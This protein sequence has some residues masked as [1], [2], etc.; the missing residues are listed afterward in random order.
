MTKRKIECFKIGNAT[1]PEEVLS[2]Y[3]L[4]TDEDI[5]TS[6]DGDCCTSIPTKFIRND[7]NE[8]IEAYCERCIDSGINS[9]IQWLQNWYPNALD[10][11]FKK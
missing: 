4:E 7:H 8:V 1:T 2:N 6:C 10:P 11:S 3:Y 5:P 9:A